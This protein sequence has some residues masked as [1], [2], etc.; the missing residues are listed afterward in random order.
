MV[1]TSVSLYDCGLYSHA[2]DCIVNHVFVD[3]DL[4]NASISTG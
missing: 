2:D 4:Q 1:G 3:I